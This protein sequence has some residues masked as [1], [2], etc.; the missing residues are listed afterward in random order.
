MW[1]GVWIYEVTLDP[2]TTP[3]TVIPVLGPDQLEAW[4]KAITLRMGEPMPIPESHR[5]EVAS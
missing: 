1:N 2:E 4:I 3:A 5:I